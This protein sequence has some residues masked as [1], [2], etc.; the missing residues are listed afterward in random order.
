MQ[1]DVTRLLVDSIIIAIPLIIAAIGGLYS[2]R[3]GVVN[4][5]IEGIMTVGAFAG[6]LAIV[7][8][9]GSNIS[10]QIGD[11]VILTQPQTL[12]LIAMVVG[13]VA[14]L[15]FSVIHAVFTVKLKSDQVITGI[16][17]NVIA[18]GLTIFLT[19]LIFNSKE[20]AN[21]EN[22]RIDTIKFGQGDSLI[23]RLNNPITYTAIAIIAATVYI[24]KSTKF[25]LRLR[26]VGENPYA[27]EA[28]GIDVMRYRIIG[29]LIS[30]MLAG[31]AGTFVLISGGNNTF[32]AI[33]I[34]GKGFMALAILIFGGWRAIPIVLAGLF[35]Q[36]IATIP[37]QITG[38][39]INQD[40]LDFLKVALPFIISL[41][42]L[43]FVSKNSKAP[44]SLGK[45]FEKQD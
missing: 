28:V 4:I 24:F 20:T 35:F 40:L 21:I 29:V 9:Q 23:S 11:F 13:A 32:S 30:G 27:S 19:Q 36:V 38:S 26:S 1:I 5:G 44:K 17:I 10:L 43:V 18:L 33:T 39:T 45:V 14:G 37:T 16:A 22:T 42:A 3:G 2:E 8:L 15:L 7:Q 25:G 34:N 31:L 6:A 12:A 41:I